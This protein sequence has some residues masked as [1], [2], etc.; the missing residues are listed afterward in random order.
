MQINPFNA[1]I[2]RAAA[3]V[4]DKVSPIEKPHKD[5]ALDE[6]EPKK[7]ADKVLDIFI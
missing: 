5:N 3:C 7:P 6:R 4:P 1:A 2:R